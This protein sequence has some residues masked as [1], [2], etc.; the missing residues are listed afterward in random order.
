M[1]PTTI[2]D[3]LY[4]AFYI[5]EAKKEQKLWLTKDCRA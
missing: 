2:S 5:V 4:N 3:S 1:L